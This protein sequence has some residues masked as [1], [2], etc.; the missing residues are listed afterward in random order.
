MNQ[1]GGSGYFASGVPG[2]EAGWLPGDPP[3][4]H[5][6]AIK[7]TA[8]PLDYCIIFNI[9]TINVQFVS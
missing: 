2:N 1:F 6:S 7:A 8:A 4:P 9:Y 5:R 3:P